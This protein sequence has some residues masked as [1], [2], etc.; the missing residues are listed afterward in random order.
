VPVK[1]IVRGI[2]ALRPGAP[3][4]SENIRVKSIVGRYLEHSRVFCFRNGGDGDEGEVYIGSGDWMMRNLRER[5]EVMA[6]VRDPALRKRL[7]RVLAVYWA[8][9][10]ASRWM[11]HDGGYARARPAPGEAP[12]NAQE[13]LMREAA[14]DGDLPQPPSLWED[15]LIPAREPG[16]R[17]GGGD[18]V[19]ASA[20]LADAAQPP[21]PQSKGRA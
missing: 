15:R 7:I 16:A 20:L 6:P 11:G 4:L 12:L 1:L 9:N 10:T 17:E 5:V 13:W 18:A 19:P 14:G 2:C 3:G 21:R 8:D